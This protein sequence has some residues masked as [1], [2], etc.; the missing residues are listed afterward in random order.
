M[1][2]QVNFFLL[3]DDLPIVER[4]IRSAGAVMFLPGV[5]ARPALQP[6]ETVTMSVSDMGKVGLRVYVTEV[7]FGPWVRFRHIPQQGHFLVDHGSPVIEF[8]RSYFDGH[9]LRR[10]RLYFYTGIDHPSGFSEWADK[11]L[12]SVRRTLTRDTTTGPHYYGPHA[13]R[14]IERSHAVCNR[15]GTELIAGAL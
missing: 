15:A 8:D 10:G 13:K 11:V 9:V 1:G 5:V 3:P 14:W 6:L 7:H 2:H 4:A 12:R